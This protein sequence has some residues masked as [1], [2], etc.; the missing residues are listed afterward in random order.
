M[1]FAVSLSDEK[2][3]EIFQILLC[4]GLFYQKLNGGLPLECIGRYEASLWRQFVQVLF[5]LDQ[6]KYHR[7]AASQGRFKPHGA[8]APKP[9][10]SCP[11]AAS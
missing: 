2:R 4:M 10:Q 7:I 9:R 3:R 5:S 11:P 8:G 1:S 6:A